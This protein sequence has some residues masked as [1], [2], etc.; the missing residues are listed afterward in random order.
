MTAPLVAV[1]I[2][3][4]NRPQVVLEAVQSVLDEQ[5]VTLELIVVD[6]GSSDGTSEVVAALPSLDQ[7]ITV[8]HQSNA[9]QS[10]A[11]NAGVAAATAR[12]VTFL[13]SDD[14]F[15]PGRLTVQL[16]AW[17]R[18]ADERPVV[19]GRERVLIH[20]G[21]EPPPHIVRRV[22][23]QETVYHTSALLLRED[24]ESVGGFDPGLRLAEDIDFVIRL[25]DAGLKLVVIDDVV[26]TRRVGGDNLVYDSDVQRSWMI[27]LRRRV[28][29]QRALL[30]AN[31]E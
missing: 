26:L 22:A 23:G 30:A 15:E 25:E 21:I 1:V 4:F 8:L 31:E 12:F 10:V 2:P 14:L 18:H 9:G 7:R 5:D 11:R 20:D 28:A 17:H 16:E 27:L 13:D 24:F 29:R 6:D 19:V 3:V